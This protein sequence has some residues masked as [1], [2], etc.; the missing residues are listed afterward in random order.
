VLSVSLAAA[1]R[2]AGMSWDPAP[3]DCFVIPDREL[4]DQTFVIS[5]MTIEVHNLPSGQLLGFN[6]TTE[7]A[8]DDV[9]KDEV[10]WMPREDQ[11]RERL[12]G[13]FLRLER[14]PGAYRV[15]LAVDGVSV[16][17]RADSVE[18]AYARAVLYRLTGH[19]AP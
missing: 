17:I 15:I 19:S 14:V 12:D 5:D 7:W 4:D 18:D 3:G 6:G 11:L 13:S 10:L 2:Q 8:L 16:E 1:L 9:E